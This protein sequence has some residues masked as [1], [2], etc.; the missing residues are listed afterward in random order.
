MHNCVIFLERAVA[1]VHASSGLHNNLDS[2]GE[3]PWITCRCLVRGEGNS[4]RRWESRGWE[5]AT[6]T[7]PIEGFDT[8]IDRFS[9]GEQRALCSDNYF[10]ILVLSECDPSNPQPATRPFDD[11]EGKVSSLTLLRKNL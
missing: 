4:H 8:V 3:N 1:G 6:T 10:G 9:P 7:A 2:V 5:S 11:D